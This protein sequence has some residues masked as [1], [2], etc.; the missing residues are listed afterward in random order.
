MPHASE[1]NSL[2]HKPGVPLAK[3]GR[4]VMLR[5]YGDANA[6]PLNA[7]AQKLGVHLF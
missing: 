3:V 4:S 5:A 6:K 7:V 2:S 1:A